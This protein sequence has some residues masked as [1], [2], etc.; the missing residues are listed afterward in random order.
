MEK[1]STLYSKE[2]FVSAREE[3]LR[4][5]IDPIVDITEHAICPSDNAIKNILNFSRALKV[6]SSGKKSQIGA[7]EI[8]IN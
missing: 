2:S 6:I 5:E 8:V 1:N 3:A 4:A 7:I